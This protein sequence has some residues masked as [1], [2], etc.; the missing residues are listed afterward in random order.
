M[1]RR[2]IAFTLLALLSFLR[3]FHLDVYAEDTGAQRRRPLVG[4]VWFGDPITV[5]PWDAAFRDG[6]RRL[7]YAEGT[8]F[9]FI[10][11]YANGDAAKLPAL[12]KELVA[13]PVDVLVV[14]SKT[15]KDALATTKT[16]PIVCPSMGDVV[17][18]GL[19]SSL[20]HP[21]G[22]LTGSNGLIV[23]MQAKLLEMTREL[24][25]GIKRIDVIFDK[26]DPSDVTDAET[27]R[28]RASQLGIS[29]RLLGIANL[30]DVRAALKTMDRHRAQLLIVFDDPLTDL[31]RELIMR[32]ANHRVPVITDGKDWIRRGAILTYA[33]DYYEMYRHAAV[34]VDRILK[35]AKPGDLPIEQPTKFDLVVNVRTAKALG[36]TIPTSILQR[37]TEIIQ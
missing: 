22:N 30:N 29:I 28:T 2:A 6:M 11:R 7:G 9:T 23:E 16:V 34:F 8:N 31:H 15:I 14:G 17:R 18:D 36:L 27:F 4:A 20:Q 37:A 3:S 33:A 13:L 26:G 19:V 5:Q 25:P 24:V 32:F 12:L 21:G 35:G 10:T 1:I